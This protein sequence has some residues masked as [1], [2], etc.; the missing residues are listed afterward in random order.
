M[1]NSS[2]SRCQRGRERSKIASWCAWQK[3]VE[4]L[5]PGGLSRLPYISGKSRLG[6]LHEGGRTHSTY[7]AFIR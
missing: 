6:L 5:V 3:P 7:Y 2:R 1:R 4:E